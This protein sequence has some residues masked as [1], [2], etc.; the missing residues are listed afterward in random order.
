MAADN[1]GMVMVMVIVMMM[2]TTMAMT[3]TMTMT[4]TMMML[5]MLML[6][7]MVLM[8]VLVV[9]WEVWPTTGPCDV[10]FTRVNREKAGPGPR[11]G[12][13]GPGWVP[14]RDTT[15]FPGESPG[16]ER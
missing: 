10:T 13:A 7:L 6:M 9:S 5:M 3:M 8:L 4:M 2:M 1:D 16:R 15:V 14:H 12:R 11:G